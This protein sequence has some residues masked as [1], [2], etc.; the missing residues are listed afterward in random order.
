M[1]FA[2]IGQL[3]VFLWM[4]VAGAAVGLTYSAF[5]A[6]RRL[7]CAGFWLTL[8]ADV[9][10]GAAAAAILVVALFLGSYGQLRL[11]ELLGA[12]LGLILYQLG[13]KMLIHRVA[14]AASHGFC[15][16]L[17]AIRRNRL[18]KVIFR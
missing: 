9:L 2:T 6:L 13:P 15:H 10:F 8:L 14:N 18:I 17:A 12:G 3:P 16:I 4:T 1:L 7:L 11:F 5:S